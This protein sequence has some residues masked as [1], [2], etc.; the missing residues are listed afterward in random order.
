MHGTFVELSDDELMHWKYIKRVRQN[1]RWVYYYNNSN[2]KTDLESAK[3]EV[4]DAQKQEFEA[5][6]R[7]LAANKAA[8]DIDN[9]GFIKKLI[10]KDNKRRADKDVA[11][12]Q[13][14]VEKL[15][16]KYES[17]EFRV[18]MEKQIVK[19]LRTVQNFFSKLFGRK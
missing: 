14:R 11:S 3:N 6:K 5:S 2:A 13:K 4:R 15:Y 10:L 7:Q 1:G 12:A 8:E 16:K 18:N 9:V 17:V 19:G